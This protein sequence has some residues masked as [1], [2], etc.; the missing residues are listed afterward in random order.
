MHYRYNPHE[1]MPSAARA[2]VPSKEPTMNRFW[3][4]L[5]LLAGGMWMCA[6]SAQ[7]A[8]DAKKSDAKTAA[9]TPLKGEMKSLKGEKI[10][11][12]DYRGKVVMIVNT[13]SFCGNTPQYGDLEQLWKKYGEKG[14]VVLGFPAN[15]FGKQEPGSDAEIAEFCTKN[16]RV[17]FPMFSKIVVKGEGKAPLYEYLTSKR[18]N[19]KFSGEITWNFE[20]F[21][22]GRDGKVAAR[23]K[24]GV[25]PQTTEIVK[26]I[27]TEL[28]KK[29]E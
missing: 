10:D 24:P 21:L 20:K 7:A 26:A 22:I 16:Y 29:A 4:L 3:Q 6:A 13:A 12:A 19:P 17:S 1:A 14:F 11:L 2:R 9:E 25:K 27:E 23:F 15:E 8:D 28:E 5:L 18:T